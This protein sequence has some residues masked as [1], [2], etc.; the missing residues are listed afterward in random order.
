MYME[1]SS[2][3]LEWFLLWDTGDSNANRITAIVAR[4]TAVQNMY[5]GNILCMHQIIGG[6]EKSLGIEFE[7]LMSSLCWDQ[8]STI[9]PLTMYLL[10][11]DYMLLVT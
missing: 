7:I 2:Q 3:G 10:L 8:I 9:L 6:Y 4:E 11:L 1:R 5:L